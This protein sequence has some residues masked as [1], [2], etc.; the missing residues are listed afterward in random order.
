ECV[1]YNFGDSK[2]SFLCLADDYCSQKYPFICE[3]NAA[4]MKLAQ[5]TQ[6]ENSH[7]TPSETGTGTGTETGTG[8]GPETGSNIIDFEQPPP[9]PPTSSEL[10]TENHE[11][12]SAVCCT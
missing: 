3:M 9:P 6:N 4:S 12:P 1:T 2:K 11:S 5:T 7:G 10:D 8:T